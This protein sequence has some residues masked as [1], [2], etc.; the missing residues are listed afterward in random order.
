[1]SSTSI[2]KGLGSIW[3]LNRN[4][5]NEKVDSSEFF[6]SRNILKIEHFDEA[7]FS[8]TR[9][10]RLSLNSSTSILVHESSFKTC[11]TPREHN[12]SNHYGFRRQNGQRVSIDLAGG[13]YSFRSV[14]EEDPSLSSLPLEKW[15]LFRRF[16]STIISFKLSAHQGMV[17]AQNESSL[18]SSIF[19]IM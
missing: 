1:M 8:R 6:S 19:E 5:I 13:V 17:F 11:D 16:G 10:F 14:A 2:S 7:Q 15:R 9:M 12:C 4:V 18:S 3:I